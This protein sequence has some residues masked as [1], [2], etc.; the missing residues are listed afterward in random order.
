[1]KNANILLVILS[2]LFPI[3]GIILFFVKKNDNAQ[4]AQ[5]YLYA[6]IA[7]FVLGLLLAL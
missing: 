5:S 2:F 3:V 1:M 6:G 7:G 4:A